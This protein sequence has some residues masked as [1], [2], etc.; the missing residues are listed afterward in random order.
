MTSGKLCHTVRLQSI[1]TMFPK[2]NPLTRGCALGVERRKEQS[3]LA[4]CVDAQIASTPRPAEVLDIACCC[5]S[6]AEARLPLV[7][8][9]LT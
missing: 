2:G 3:R 6:H 4:F 7:V 1:T 5:K 8:T 9:T